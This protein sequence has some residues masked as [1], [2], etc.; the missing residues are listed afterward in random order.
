M[1]PNSLNLSQ[2]N[3]SIDFKLTLNGSLA[4]NH[5]FYERSH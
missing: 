5:G 4:T 2:Y 3:T 1:N